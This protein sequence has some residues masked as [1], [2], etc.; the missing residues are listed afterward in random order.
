MNQFIDPILLLKDHIIN[1]KKIEKQGNNLIFTDGIKLKLDTL[2][3][4][5]RSHEDKKQYTLGSIWF[6]LIHRNDS[7]AEY[8]TELQKEKIDAI[9]SMDKNDIVDF[10]INSNNN[11]NIIDENL[12]Q[13]SLIFLGKKKNP[14]DSLE[15]VMNDELKKKT[16]DNINEAIEK[17][18][19]KKQRLDNLDPSLKVI[20]Y[21]NIKKK[22]SL[23]RNS[24]LRPMSTNLTSFGNL[25]SICNKTFG[26][27]SKSAHK[28]NESMRFIDELTSSDDLLGSRAIIIVPSAFSPGNL[29]IDNAKSFLMDSVYFDPNQEQRNSHDSLVFKKNVLGKELTFEVHSNVRNFNKSDWKRI[30]AVFVQ[31]SDWEFSDWPKNENITSILMKIKGFH[32]KYSDLPTNE[33]VKKWNVKVLE[34]NRFKRH[35]DGIIQTE[36]WNLMEQFL[37]QPRYREKKL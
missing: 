23:N 19:T 30:V 12:R 4:F 36:F 27:A 5:I 33:N 16:Q 10:F 11:V 37:D 15:Q 13:Q 34:I 32:L 2:T 22:H 14:S 24:I 35:V 29:N 18:N 20:D 8:R 28:S 26:V 3:G 9:L 21:I 25:L 6:Y 31:G 1:D 17:L 7:Y